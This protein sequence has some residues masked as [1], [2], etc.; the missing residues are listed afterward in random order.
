MPTA[1]KTEQRLPKGFN[2]QVWKAIDEWFGKRPQMNPPCVRD[3]LNPHDQHML[4]SQD[5][6]DDLDKEVEETLP[7]TKEEGNLPFQT[8]SRSS[9]PSATARSHCTPPHSRGGTGHPSSTSPSHAA[10]TTIS[11][12]T[13]CA[14]LVINL[15]DAS[16]SD[17][18]R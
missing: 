5:D 2:R 3:L 14:V 17:A 11:L 4:D 12:S 13:P 9:M 7:Q 18:K 1:E 8:M 16:S 6:N 15:S 10:G